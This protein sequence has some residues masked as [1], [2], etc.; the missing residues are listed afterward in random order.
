MAVCG[1]PWSNFDLGVV[2]TLAFIICYP[3]NDF[4]S[5]FF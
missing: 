4:V 2:D 1:H 3:Y 5:T